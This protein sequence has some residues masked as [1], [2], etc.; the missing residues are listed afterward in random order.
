MHSKRTA[1]APT[2]FVGRIKM[3]EVVV[4]A[5]QV[6]VDLPLCIFSCDNLGELSLMFARMISLPKF[7]ELSTVCGDFLL[8]MSWSGCGIRWA[9]LLRAARFSRSSRDYGETTV[10]IM[11]L[12]NTKTL[13]IFQFKGWGGNVICTW[14]NSLGL[15][16]YVFILCIFNFMVIGQ[17]NF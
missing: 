8:R 3:I 9:S 6:H 16:P 4:D 7:V 11:G 2:T 14:S 1:Q 10:F 12:S 5:W 13:K 15:A 17:S